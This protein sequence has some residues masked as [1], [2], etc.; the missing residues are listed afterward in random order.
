M[1]M[2][3]IYSFIGLIQKSG[4]LFSGDECVEKLIKRRKC[5]LIIIAEDASDNTKNKFIRLSKESNIPFVIFGK[6]QELGEKIGKPDRAILAIN[7]INFVN[8]LIKKIHEY[9]GGEISAKN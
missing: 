6:K 8:G 1:K 2:N 7:D 4:K 9:N 5:S 3:D